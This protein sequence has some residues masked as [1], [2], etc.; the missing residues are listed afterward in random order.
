[1]P[2]APNSGRC[3]PEAEIL[4]EN[5]NVTSYRRVRVVLFNGHDTARK[6]P[7]GWPAGGKGA[8]NWRISRSPHPF[9]IREFEVL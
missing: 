3:P 1:V 7:S 8:C 9:E 6:E 5:G 4:D 2:L